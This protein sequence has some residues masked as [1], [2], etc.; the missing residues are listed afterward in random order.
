MTEGKQESG[1]KNSGIERNQRDVFCLTAQFDSGEREREI[2]IDYPDCPQQRKPTGRRGREK[3]DENFSDRDY[4][5]LFVRGEKK[6][7]ILGETI[8][9]IVC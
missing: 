8:V 2:V 9:M 7:V 3:G 4:F 6:G 1:R 5:R